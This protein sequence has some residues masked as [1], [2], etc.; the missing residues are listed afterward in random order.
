MDFRVKCWWRKTQQR[1]SFF[2]VRGKHT[3]PAVTVNNPIHFRIVEDQGYGFENQTEQSNTGHNFQLYSLQWVGI[4]DPDIYHYIFH[5]QSIPP[6]GA[7][8]GYYIS[9]EADGLIEQGRIILEIEKRKA[10]YSQVQ[11]ILARDLPYVNLWYWDN[12]AIMKR[13]IS[14]Y[15][16]Y[17]AADYI[18]LKDTWID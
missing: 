12:I 17:P 4:V 13:N 11:K 14:G 5:S 10:V 6:N 2:R 15:K 16:L 1:L 8:R 3:D 7:N 9:Q 18:S